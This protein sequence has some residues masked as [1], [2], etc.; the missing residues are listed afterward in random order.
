MPDAVVETEHR[1]GEHPRIAWADRAMLHRASQEFG[2]RELERAG[3][4]APRTAG[5]LFAL[6]A[7]LAAQRRL[8]GHEHTI[9]QHVALREF[10]TVVA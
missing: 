7:G 3:L 5:L 10:E 4:P 6:G 2:P 1:A 8:L 9:A